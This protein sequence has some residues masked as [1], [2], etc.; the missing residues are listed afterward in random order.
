MLNGYLFDLP[1]E[2][3]EI[4]KSLYSLLDDNTFTSLYEFSEIL[5]QFF[6]RIVPC[7]EQLLTYKK[8]VLLKMKRVL[9]EK[10]VQSILEDLERLP[11]ADRVMYTENHKTLFNTAMQD[12]EFIDFGNFDID[13]VI[14]QWLALA[15]TLQ[16]R[17]EAWFS[18]K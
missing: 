3:F 4:I 5:D 1:K 6:L 16:R 9:V 10:A 12:P 7:F 18:H 14:E 11:Q 17:D 13:L 2:A 15:K 8:Q